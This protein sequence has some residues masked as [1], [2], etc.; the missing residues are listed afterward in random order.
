MTLPSPPLQ[1]EPSDKDGIFKD[2]DLRL[3]P[4][5]QLAFALIVLGIM[6]LV[7]LVVTVHG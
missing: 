7:A 1:P 5:K 6:A 2:C 4:A 3:S